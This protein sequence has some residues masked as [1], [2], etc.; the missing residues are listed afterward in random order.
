MTALA[1]RGH[2][3]TNLQDNTA[4]RSELHA[5]GSHSMI[6]SSLPALGR[7]YRRMPYSLVDV[8][9]DIKA[10]CCDTVVHYLFQFRNYGTRNSHDAY[11]SMEVAFT[12]DGQCC[13]GHASLMC[14]IHVC[15][16]SLDSVALV[17]IA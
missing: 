16:H 6:A 7:R 3:N 11:L 5:S 4:C 1:R 17:A 8:H 15:L 10:S 14:Q 2:D 13:R 9:A 12:P